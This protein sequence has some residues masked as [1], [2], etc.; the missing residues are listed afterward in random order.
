MIQ[1]NALRISKI[2]A[3]TKNRLKVARVNQQKK[4]SMMHA[5]AV[6][7]IFLGTIIRHCQINRLPSKPKAVQWDFISS[8][9]QDCN[10]SLSQQNTMAFRA[11]KFYACVLGN[12]LE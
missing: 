9:I 2:Y 1:T 11:I 5:G 4:I 8:N 12:Y 7:C 6:H 3:E 10:Q